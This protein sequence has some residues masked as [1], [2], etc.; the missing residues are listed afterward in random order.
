MAKSKQSKAKKPV[1]KTTKSKVKKTTA[2]KAKT[3]SAKAKASA[4]SKAKK[5]P[6][7]TAVKKKAVQ[8]KAAKP[9]AVKAKAKAIKSE[10]DSK[11]AEKAKKEA[12]KN[13][14]SQPL[15]PE[16]MEVAKKRGRKPKS[17]KVADGFGEDQLASG[18][19][20]M[21]P[22]DEN[23]EKLLALGRQKGYLT[24]DDLNEALPA[25]VNAPEMMDDLLIHLDGN[26]IE[27]VDSEDDGKELL[28][29]QSEDSGSND[30]QGSKADKN[31]KKVLAAGKSDQVD[32]PVRLY[33][34]QMGQISLLKRDEE[35]ALAIKIE[36][37]EIE[38]KKAVMAFSI[39]KRRIMEILKDICDSKVSHED[40]IKEDFDQRDDVAKTLRR[41]ASILKKLK[42]GKCSKE[43]EIELMLD[44]KLTTQVVEDLITQ[45]EITYR[46]QNRLER[47]LKSA[48]KKKDSER[49]QE[50][51]NREKANKEFLGEPMK[52][53]FDKIRTAKRK[54]VIYNRAKK[55][56]VAANLRLVVSI[57]KK[58]TNRGLSFLDLIQ[59]GNIGLMK[60]VD[61]FEYK[62]GYKFST[63]ATWWIRQAVTRS[64]ADQARTIRIPV[65]MT[66]TI[67]KLVRISRA[68][69]QKNGEEPSPEEIGKHMRM[70][71][72]K[73]RGILKIAQE[74]ISLQTPIGD[75]G[76]TS[77]GDFIEDK[78]AVSPA[79][80]TTYSMLKEH[81][82]EV[83]ATLTERE[84][85]V[86]RFRFGIGDGYPRTLE[87]VGSI[88][89][90]TRER[91]RQIEA[92]ALRK[93]RHPI[94][95]RKLKTFLDL[96]VGEEIDF[97]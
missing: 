15:L 65:H 91:V 18:G 46:D 76:D 36:T 19:S 71:V 10:A 6:A 1:K 42:S 77:F 63:Y 57:A 33:L 62:R 61:K 93:L 25:N 24:F 27:I 37:A 86:L 97:S 5:A 84:R 75:D 17:S 56:L 82:E 47:E 72:N 3:A 13:T 60:A 43:K 95:S 73:V 7:K 94:R 31:G 64:I 92:K 23:A 16:G 74:P 49:L 96:G 8:K 83:L 81:M 28:D 14:T 78:A 29:Q 68:L 85:K 50:L 88:F 44:T 35:L 87:E 48:K 80:A 69:V 52:A 32:D 53:I 90:V 26:N 67:N 39:T 41:M 66:E 9:A 34:K 79:N 40:Y 4:K 51:L 55:E 70:G 89:N 11:K 30:E 54:D 12:V 45:I 2:A 21:Y 59:E 38:F 20:D 58:Y 22:S